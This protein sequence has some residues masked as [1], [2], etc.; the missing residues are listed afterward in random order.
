MGAL[1]LGVIL[2]LVLLGMLLWPGR[3]KR[4]VASESSDSMMS[5]VE[6]AFAP[7]QS[8]SFGFSVRQQANEEDKSVLAQMFIEKRNAKHREELRKE[9]IELL[10]D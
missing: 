9:F 7:A 3:E 2:V 8:T 6:K 4:P 10:S 1:G 5:R